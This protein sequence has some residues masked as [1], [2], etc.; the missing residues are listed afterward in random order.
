MLMA[1]KVSQVVLVAAVDAFVFG[2][3]VLTAFYQ[4]L[5]Q[6]TGGY[7][8]TI[9]NL[10]LDIITVFT[11]LANHDVIFTLCILQEKH[12]FALSDLFMAVLLVLVQFIRLAAGLA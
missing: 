6:L 11:F 2:L 5:W 1:F 3:V 9:H 12:L 7:D 10:G 4:N 8:L